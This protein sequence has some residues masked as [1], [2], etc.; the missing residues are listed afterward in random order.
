MQCGPV[1][2]GQLAGRNVTKTVGNSQ[3]F[4]IIPGLR[5]VVSSKKQVS[6]EQLLAAAQTV[7]LRHQ[8]VDIHYEE[9]N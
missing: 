9:A 6:P 1:L 7:S 3:R 5:M 8:S 2:A 4:V